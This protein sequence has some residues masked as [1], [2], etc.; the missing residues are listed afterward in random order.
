MKWVVRYFHHQ[1]N[2]WEERQR[3]SLFTAGAAAYAARQYSRWQNI[4]AAADRL[5]KVTN[6]N[7]TISHIM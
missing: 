2:V 5:F 4:A 1:A 3:G 7:H 6:P